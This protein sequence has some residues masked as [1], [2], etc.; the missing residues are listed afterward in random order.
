MSSRNRDSLVFDVLES[1]RPQVETWLVDWVAK[2]PLRRADFFETETGN[3]RLNYAPG[4]AGP[5]NRRSI[6]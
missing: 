4:S 2:E 5:L 3:C 6:K 1:I